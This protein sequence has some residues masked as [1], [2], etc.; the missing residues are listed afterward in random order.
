MAKIIKSNGKIENVE[1]KNGSN[2]TLE[3]LKAF[4]GGWVE[5][6]YMPHDELMVVNEE[7]KLADLPIN[8]T[9]TLIYQ[10]AFGYSDVI[11]GDVLLCENYQIQ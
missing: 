4:V 7:G 8:R 3:E 1:P 10:E 2:F 5:I 11:V 9:A 6:V